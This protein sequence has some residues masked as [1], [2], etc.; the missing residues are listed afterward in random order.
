MGFLLGWETRREVPLYG[1]F[2]YAAVGRY[3]CRAW[4]LLELSLTGY[5]AR[6]TAATAVLLY[7][8]FLT[9]HWTPDLRLPLAA[10]PAAMTAG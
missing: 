5:R 1:G 2:M 9:R 10:L 6:A 8:G 7:A 4:R 3:L